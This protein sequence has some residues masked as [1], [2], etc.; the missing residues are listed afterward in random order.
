[1]LTLNQTIEIFDQFS[2][3]HKAL[4]KNQSRNNF[5][6]GDSAE[7]ES[8]STRQ[9]PL[10][11]VTKLPTTPDKSG[12]II[13]KFQVEV[14]DKVNLGE[15]NETHVLSDTEQV[16]LDLVWYLESIAD[17]GEILLNLGAISDITD[18]TE[19][20]DD[21]VSGNYMTVEIRSHAEN[22]TCYLPIN[23]GTILRSNYIYINGSTITPTS[24]M[25]ILT[26][27]FIYGTDP[28]V[29]AHTPTAIISV[30]AVASPLFETDDY[31]RV[32]TTFTINPSNSIVSNGDKIRI[33][34][35]YTS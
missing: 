35:A 32:T 24:D 3:K 18:F 16:L 8:F 34:Y 23:S 13:R 26:E 17:G 25:S 5:F 9:Y 14:T 28:L 21:M 30:F 33:T 1:M 31:T 2:F 27:E 29:L 12:L 15:S 20:R 22:T 19:K 7:V 6:F 11:W 4:G 10:M